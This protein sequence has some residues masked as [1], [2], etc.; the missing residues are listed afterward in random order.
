MLLLIKFQKST[1]SLSSASA[2]I[3]HA[4]TDIR[5][6]AKG[7]IKQVPKRVTDCPSPGGSKPLEVASLWGLISS[8]QTYSA[9]ISC[10]ARF[11]REGRMI[12]LLDK[13]SDA[14]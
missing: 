12:D 9:P 8:A 6:V 1:A 3:K 11:R 13:F 4:C 7:D 2:F 14:D 5:W 10:G